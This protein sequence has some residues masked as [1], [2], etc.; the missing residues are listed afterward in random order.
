GLVDLAVLD[1][2]V[3]ERVVGAGRPLRVR[4]VRRAGVRHG[5]LDVAG[6]GRDHGAALE[7]AEDLGELQARLRRA[8]ARAGEHAGLGEGR[9]ALAVPVDRPH[10]HPAEVVAAGETDQGTR[11][12]PG[13]VLALDVV[14]ADH[15]RRADPLPDLLRA[16]VDAVFRVQ[17][18]ELRV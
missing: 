17:G 14:L 3:A 10:G 1:D 7:L 15:D 18:R 2:L 4:R 8:A 5:G 6:A 9:A 12:V 11:V 13:E 16:Q